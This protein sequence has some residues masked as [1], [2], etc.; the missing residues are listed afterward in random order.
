MEDQIIDIE[1]LIEQGRYLEARSLTQVAIETSSSIRLKQLH[2]LAVSKS[3]MPLQAKE[4]LEKLYQEHPDEAETAGILGGIYKTLFKQTQDS[5]YAIQSRDTY[6]KNF[7][8]T[9]DYYTGINAATMSAIAGQARKGREIAQEVIT[10]LGEVKSFWEIATL[11]EAY[12]LTKDNKKAIG[13]YQKARQL[14]GMDWGKVS[15]VNNQLWLVNHYMNVPSD[16]LKIFNPPAVAAFVGHMIDRPDRSSPRFPSS[17]EGAVKAAIRASIRS[18]KIAIGYCSLACG[19]DILFAEAMEEEGGE[20]NIF[21]PFNKEDFIRESVAFAGSNWTE[22]F[23]ALMGKH[24]VHFITQENYDNHTD[25]FSMQSKVVLGTTL[26]RRSMVHS[27]A[28]LLTV[29]SDFDFS[30]LEGGTRDN[31]SLWPFK[32][33]VINISPNNFLTSSQAGTEDPTSIQKP[34]P[35]NV[36]PALYTLVIDSEVTGEWEKL[37]EKIQGAFENAVVPPLAFNVRD[38]KLL[39][40]FLSLRSLIDFTHL[41]GKT[42]GVNTSH[43]RLSINGG[44]IALDDFHEK[45]TVKYKVMAGAHLD[46]AIGGHQY[47][48]PGS[49]I[50]LSPI[51]YELPLHNVEIEL[52]SR[53]NMESG[54]VAEVFKVL[55]SSQAL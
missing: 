4:F 37:Y 20:V 52:L 50:A 7:T 12:L 18:N 11:G 1:Q 9:G 2:A 19:G 21:L 39:I 40:G 42:K 45:D 10:R 44:P 24:P 43:L 49:C 41:L 35:V 47:S 26:L 14:A 38:S 54:E 17:I 25:L 22:R 53:V 15:S 48:L 32:D 6:L 3:G 36:R 51:A 34:L 31:M 46:I 55:I 5:E 29:L 28:F 16:I 30:R 27:D 8:L 33:K 23:D 13:F